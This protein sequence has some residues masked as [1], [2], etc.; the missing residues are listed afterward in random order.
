MSTTPT[1]DFKNAWMAIKGLESELRA[2]EMTFAA[3]KLALEPSYPGFSKLADDGLAAARQSPIL[4]ERMRKQYDELLEKCLPQG[5]EVL[6]PEEVLK[7][8]CMP[9]Q[10][11]KIQ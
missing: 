6:S 8:L 5:T 11:T 10:T 7:L 1:E 2:Y 3:L 4:A 9:L